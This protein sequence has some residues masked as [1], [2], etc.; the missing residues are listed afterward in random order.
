MRIGDL[1][2][3]SMLASLRGRGVINEVGIVVGEPRLPEF[4]PGEVVFHLVR[5]SFGSQPFDCIE[6]ELEVISAAR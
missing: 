1:V 6:E 4:S 2:R 5:V 3:A